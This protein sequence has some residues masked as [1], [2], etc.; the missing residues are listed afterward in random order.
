[1]DDMRVYSKMEVCEMLGISY[2]TL[3]NWYNWQKKELSSNPEQREYLPRPIKIEHKRGRP[4]MWSKEMVEMLRV[5]Q[6]GMVRGRN[7]IYGKYTNVK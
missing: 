5:Y 4:L 1:M 6:S 3:Q 7:G 2:F